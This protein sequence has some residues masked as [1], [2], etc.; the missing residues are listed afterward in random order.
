[1]ADLYPTSEPTAVP[2]LAAGT[3]YTIQNK[4]GDGLCYFTQGSEDPSDPDDYNVLTPLG[5][6]QGTAAIRLNSGQSLYIWGNARVIKLTE[7]V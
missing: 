1:M 2:S 7:S 3:T 4:D 5:T 6:N